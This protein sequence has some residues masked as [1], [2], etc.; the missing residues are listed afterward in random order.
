MNLY[1]LKSKTKKKLHCF[2]FFPFS[3]PT[4]VQTTICD[5]FV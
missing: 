3:K 4:N 2:Q 1:K 5:N